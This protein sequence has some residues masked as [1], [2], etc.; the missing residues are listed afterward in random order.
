MYGGS[1]GLGA[2]RHD[3]CATVHRSVLRPYTE[4]IDDAEEEEIRLTGCVEQEIVGIPH[5]RLNIHANA[6]IPTIVLRSNYV[7][8]EVETDELVQ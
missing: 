6:L 2:A 3:C 7:S 1:N 8:L 5:R 4:R